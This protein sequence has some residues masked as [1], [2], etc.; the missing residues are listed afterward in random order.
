MPCQE[1]DN[2]LVTRSNLYVTRGSR[3]CHTLALLLVSS[4]SMAVP[5]ADIRG[6]GVV[7]ATPERAPKWKPDE[8]DVLRLAELG[9]TAPGVKQSNGNG[10]E[11]QFSGG[12][13]SRALLVFLALDALLTGNH[14]CP[15][16]LA[17]ARTTISPRRA[18]RLSEG[19]SDAECAL[20]CVAGARGR[21]RRAD[22]L[23]WPTLRQ[24]AGPGDRRGS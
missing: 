2:T 1:G 12:L 19:G 5:R 22:F 7:I 10:G 4:Q 23:R 18:H 15:A 6:P 24:G 21:N 3:G 13:V 20:K 14:S 9:W 16:R 17:R 8:E 11:L